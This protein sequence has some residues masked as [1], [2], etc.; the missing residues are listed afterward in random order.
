MEN[1]IS[2]NNKAWNFLFEK[3]KILDEVK[4]NDIFEI[5]AEQ[6]KTS[7]REPRLM[8]K[9]DSSNNLPEVFKKNNLAI[10][11]IKRGK[12]IISYFNNYEEIHL[13]SLEEVETRFMPDYINTLDCKNIFSEAVSLNAAYISGMISDIIGEDVVPTLSGRM[14]SGKFG[15]KI[16]MKKGKIYSVNVENSQMEI[17]ASYEGISKFVIIEAKNHYV[18]D[19]I[20]RQLYYPY[21]SLKQ[22]TNKEIIPVMLIRHD[23]VFNFY[24]YSF[25][26]DEY[27]NSIKLKSIKRYILDEPYNPVELDDLY[28]V[29]ASI[30]FIDEPFKVPFPQANTFNIVLDL[31]NELNS[32]DMSAD[33]ITTYLEYDRRQTNYYIDALKYLGLVYKNKKYSLTKVGKQLVKMNQK[34]KT[35][36]IIKLILIHKPFYKAIESYLKDMEFSKKE[37][38]AAIHECRPEIKQSTAERRTST[39]ISWSKWILGITSG[40]GSVKF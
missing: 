26:D 33:D 34:D 35:I 24:I 18:K 7:G 1:W 25:D 20:I 5:T 38:N 32:R 12:Y 6:I 19:F 10:L 2:K 9:F 15:F 37:I 13:N 29:M 3:Y 31:I 30:K 28:N 40:I 23:N 27:Y 39:V 11:P 8:T 17:D 22:N 14:S 21:K 16:S 36:E 4:R